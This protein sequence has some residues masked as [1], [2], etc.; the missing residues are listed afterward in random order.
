M[1]PRL[2][3]FISGGTGT[4]S[5]PPEKC[6]RSVINDLEKY[7]QY[8]PIHRLTATKNF[9]PQLDP[10]PETKMM[11][12]TVQDVSYQEYFLSEI[13]RRRPKLKILTANC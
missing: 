1:N 11:T 4:M 2:K 9:S 12:P 10:Q 3:I 5:A 13:A 7:S 6:P 8:N